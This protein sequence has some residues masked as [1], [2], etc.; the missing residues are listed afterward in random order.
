LGNLSRIGVSVAYTLEEKGKKS[1]NEPKT[2]V[3]LH[4]QNID[5]ASKELNA[6]QAISSGRCF[7]RSSIRQKKR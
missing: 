3:T 4:R 5:Q 2:V 7:E 1:W 6:I